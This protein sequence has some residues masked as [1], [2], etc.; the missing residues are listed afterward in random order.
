MSR[1]HIL[2]ILVGI[3]LLYLIYSDTVCNGFSVGGKNKKG[4]KNKNKKGGKKRNGKEKVCDCF[5]QNFIDN[6]N[7]EGEHDLTNE[8]KDCTHKIKT[9]I[10][11]F[12]KKHKYEFMYNDNT[13][14][15]ID[16]NYKV[17]HNC[18]YIPDND[19]INTII[20]KYNGCK[21]SLLNNIEG[22]TI[23]GQPNKCKRINKNK[24]ITD[25]STQVH[26]NKKNGNIKKVKDKCICECK[27]GY[28]G[29]SC[30]IEKNECSYKTPDEVTAVLPTD[31][32]NE[33]VLFNVGKMEVDEL[34]NPIVSR[35]YQ[36]NLYDNAY[37]DYLINNK[38]DE[39]L[40]ILKN[41]KNLS[42]DIVNKYSRL[43][44]NG[45]NK[46]CDLNC[47]NKIEENV[48]KSVINHLSK[49]NKYN[50]IE[51]N[52]PMRNCSRYVDLY[53]KDCSYN[54]NNCKMTNNINFADPEENTLYL[55]VLDSKSMEELKYYNRFPLTLF[56]IDS[57]TINIIKVTIKNKENIEDRLK[58]SLLALI[59]NKRSI[60]TLNINKYLD[61]LENTINQ[62]MKQIKVY[63]FDFY[64]NT[65]GY[66]AEKY[67]RLG[68]GDFKNDKIKKVLINNESNPYIYVKDILKKSKIFKE[69]KEIDCIK[70]LLDCNGPGYDSNEYLEY[71]KC[72]DLQSFQENMCGYKNYPI[73]YTPHAE[74]M[75][76]GKKIVPSTSETGS[77]VGE[78][79]GITQDDKSKLH[80]S[81]F[82]KWSGYPYSSINKLKKNEIKN[83][84][85]YINKNNENEIILQM[86]DNV[87]LLKPPI[88][89]KHR[90]FNGNEYIWF[91]YLYDHK[92]KPRWNLY[93]WDSKSD[94][95]F[96]YE[97]IYER[98]KEKGR[99]MW[100]H[101]IDINKIDIYKL[102]RKEMFKPIDHNNI[103]K[104][105][106]KYKIKHN[107][108]INNVLKKND[109]N[110]YNYENIEKL[111]KILQS[112]NSYYNVSSHFFDKIDSKNLIYNELEN[113]KDYSDMSI[114][115]K[116][117]D[118]IVLIHV[119]D[120]EPWKSITEGGYV[121]CIYL[122]NDDGKWYLHPWDTNKNKFYDYNEITYI[123]RGIS[124]GKAQML[125]NKKKLDVKYIENNVFSHIDSKMKDMIEI[126][127][128]KDLSKSTKLKQIPFIG[129]YIS[130][131]I[132]QKQYKDVIQIM[133]NDKNIKKSKNIKYINEAIKDK[134]F[135]D[136]LIHL[137]DY[138]KDR[139]PP[140][141]KINSFSSIVGG[142][143]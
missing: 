133:E 29:N 116:L 108:F 21:H 97:K 106:V 38:K 41:D 83:Y 57:N 90:A 85:N 44:D 46:D 114:V 72:L 10:D 138:P 54:Y 143:F 95:W 4:G 34:G 32:S 3:F 71:S 119:K 61:S 75:C 33:Y 14:S 128:L 123:Y 77:T 66:L 8:E 78:T 136:K 59:K 142:T 56:N 124:L 30:D 37:Y 20:D 60:T 62:D 98:S 112:N 50:T 43:V 73:G 1:N 102:D 18:K 93:P 40:K 118:N 87:V 132:N 65:K 105:D 122:Y 23:G 80:N 47:F 121:W 25:P 9:C 31:N 35:N 55:T 109:K 42:Q 84:F 5:I 99:N 103:I 100:R 94:K 24:K 69:V 49:E 51:I 89:N 26:C 141:M 15:L 104:Y 68:T 22:F 53:F 110:I 79:S 117:L 58:K 130:N 135:S 36:S 115:K 139:W 12:D 70:Q 17:V 63:L 131:K 76:V 39:F 92:S 81:I 27:D 19:N 96:N 107:R 52:S 11:T 113:K 28:T 134:D 125:Q 137:F 82:C 140:I 13:L 120:M 91:I 111:N 45:L 6:T 127:L 2:L 16:K 129:K 67:D 101:R 7:N 88:N 126:M 74:N 86:L 64:N 48:K